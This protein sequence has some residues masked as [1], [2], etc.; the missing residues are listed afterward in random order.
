MDYGRDLAGWSRNDYASSD[1]RKALPEL[2]D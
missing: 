1:W 2:I